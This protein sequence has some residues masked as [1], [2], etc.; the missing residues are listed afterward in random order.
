MTEQE[1]ITIIGNLDCDTYKI[2][3][4]QEAKAMAIKALM[5]Q[6]MYNK[7]IEYKPNKVVR[8]R[9]GYEVEHCPNCNTDYQVD[10]RYTS[11]DDY[12]SNCGKILDSCFINYCSN[13]GCKIKQK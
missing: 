3:E 9:G 8:H 13:C 10:R 4:S 6:D 5:E 11:V 12:C 1:A 2:C 7:N